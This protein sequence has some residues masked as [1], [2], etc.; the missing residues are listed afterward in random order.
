ML[1]AKNNMTKEKMNKY[2]VEVQA[3]ERGQQVSS[4]GIRENGKL[5]SQFKNPTPYNGPQLPPTVT[6]HPMTVDVIDKKQVRYQRNNV[7][8]YLL[9]ITWQEIGEPLLRFGLH[10]LKNIIINKL[11]SP[12]KQMISPISSSRPKLINNKAEGSESIYNNKKNIR[13]SNKKV[14]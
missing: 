1:K 12:T 3:P 14:V 13:V 2:I 10:E 7:T 9:G 6:N 5:I 8:M 11:D 4:G